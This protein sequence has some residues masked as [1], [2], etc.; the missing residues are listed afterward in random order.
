MTAALLSLCSLV[1]RSTHAPL[2]IELQSGDRLILASP[3]GLGKSSLI[4]CVLGSLSPVSGSCRV[5]GRLGYAPQDYR[6]SLLPWL[7]AADNVALAARVLPRSL[8]AAAIER[9]IDVVG[10]SR[11]SLSR[12]PTQLSGG[13]QQRV[14][15]ARALAFDPEIALLD[16]PFS[17]IDAPS[18]ASILAR[19]DAHLSARRVALLLVTHQLDDAVALG[20]RVAHLSPSSEE[21]AA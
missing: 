15:L 4:R 18:R 7:S 17:A 21:R 11:A 3:N 12:A 19:L 9:A 8:R 1:A 20:A 13:A 14:S 5:A 2:S 16:E 6:A 10:L